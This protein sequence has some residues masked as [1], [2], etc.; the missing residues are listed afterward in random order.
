MWA[1]WSHILCWNVTCLVASPVSN[2]L[3]SFPKHHE[4]SPYYVYT[5]LDNPVFSFPVRMAHIKLCLW[6]NGPPPAYRP[7]TSTFLP[8]TNSMTNESVVIL[9]TTCLVPNSY[10][11]HLSHSSSQIQDSK[12]LEERKVSFGSQLTGWSHQGREGPSGGWGEAAGAPLLLQQET[13]WSSL[14]EQIRGPR[15][16]V[17]TLSFLLFSFLFSL[18][19]PTIHSWGS[20]LPDATK[21]VFTNTLSISTLVHICG[22][23]N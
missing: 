17:M 15:K 16:G 22:N 20:T 9:I 21:G 12:Q 4:L 18:G 2:S 5:S 1:E 11:G 13:V 7:N 14:S 8:Q 3:H 6:H 19:D 23:Q 10:T